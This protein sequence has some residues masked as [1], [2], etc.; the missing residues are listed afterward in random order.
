LKEI[1]DEFL[2]E[3]SESQRNQAISLSLNS[4]FQPKLKKKVEFYNTPACDK[5]WQ[6]E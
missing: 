2:N 3:F 4:K 6:A 5:T 1:K